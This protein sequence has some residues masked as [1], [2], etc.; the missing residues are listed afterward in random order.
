ME[1]RD[2][3]IFL[4]LAQELHFG[5]TAQRLHVTQSRVSHAIKKQERHIG[6]PLFLRTSRTVVLTPIGQQLREDLQRGY[7]L[8]EAAVARAN[9]TAQ[10][11]GH[12]L[13][14]GLMGAL[15]HVIRAELDAFTAAYSEVSLDVREIHF[16]DP[17]G[18]LR[19][20]EVDVQLMWLPV[21]EPDL[22]VGPTV[23]SE[24]VWLAVGAD[25][26]LASAEQATLEDL[27]DNTV[28]GLGPEVPAYWQE[29]MVPFHTPS[30]RPIR[31]G[32]Q[33]RTFQEIL[34]MIAAGRAIT[35]VQEHCLHYYAR[36][37]VTY[38]PLADAPACTWGFVWRTGTESDLI[39]A[40]AAVMEQ[41]QAPC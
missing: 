24:P 8:I 10:G 17:F 25:H 11:M 22:T 34:T 4:T 16:S 1:L 33:V 41:R 13:V 36:P 12:T 21:H 40:F 23:F 37:D 2:I 31:R 20:G 28:F 9:A 3:E 30:G 15:G 19:A 39:R 5:R 6:A 7:Q 38:V 14:L 26:P 32:P 35:T 29:A 18:P 27:G